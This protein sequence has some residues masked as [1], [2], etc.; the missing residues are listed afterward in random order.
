M[1]AIDFL[2]F[3]YPFTEIEMQQK[4][5]EGSNDVAFIMEKYALDEIIG[6][7]MYLTGHNRLEIEQ[8]YN[9]YKIIIES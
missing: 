6:F 5:C 1:K 4:K 2:R 8:M 9:D 7:T 3:N